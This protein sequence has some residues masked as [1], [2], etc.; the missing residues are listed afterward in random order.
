[1]QKMSNKIG[2]THKNVQKKL[3]KTKK[4]YGSKKHMYEKCIAPSSRLKQM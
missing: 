3:K 1:M 2:E 4:K